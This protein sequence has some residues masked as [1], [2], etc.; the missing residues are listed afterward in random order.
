MIRLPRGHTAIAS[1]FIAE[2]RRRNVLRVG[3]AYVAAAWLL[4][5]V[6]QTLFPVFSFGATA[7]RSVVVVLAIGL[8]PVLIFA[9]AFELTPEGLK[10]ESEA[11]VPESN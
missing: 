9:W 2:L 7:V 1:S 5:Q 11:R 8:L 10:R 6:A 4:I 3:A